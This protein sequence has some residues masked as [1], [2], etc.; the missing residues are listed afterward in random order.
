M[1]ST[2]RK[3]PPRD[4]GAVS[5]QPAPR[6]RFCLCGRDAKR[7]FRT[8]HRAAD[9]CGE[10]N[11]QERE[12]AWVRNLSVTLIVRRSHAPE[13]FLSKQQAAPERQR[14]PLPASKQR[15]LITDR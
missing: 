2:I 13:R 8:T 4:L 14:H 11:C 15:I 1:R 3:N 10:K 9:V 5:N 12:S 6:G 7:S